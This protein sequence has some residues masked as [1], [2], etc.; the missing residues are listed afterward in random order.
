MK[1]VPRPRPTEPTMK[2]NPI[3]MPAICGTVRRKPKCR[4]DASSMM[5][6]GPGVKNITVAN[7]TKAISSECDMVPS[8]DRWHGS[9]T[10]R[11][12][13]HRDA[14]DYGDH[15]GQPQRPKCFAERDALLRGTDALY[16]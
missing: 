12:Q 15:S 3:V 4:P 2:A 8:R 13:H 16:Q 6:C 1:M 11:Q 5:L 14:A 7:M 9:S 10:F